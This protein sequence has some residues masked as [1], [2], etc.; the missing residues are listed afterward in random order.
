MD[1]SETLPRRRREKHIAVGTMPLSPDRE[2][3][4]IMRPSYPLL[5]ATL[6][7]AALGGS[8]A[9]AQAPGAAAGVA[10]DLA[11]LRA[12]TAGFRDIAAAQAAGYPT[13]TPPCLANPPAGGMGHHYVNR[14]QVDGRLELEHP[15]ILLYAPDGTGKL[16]LV[17]VEYIIPY[18][19]LPP[20]SEA[21][22]IFGQALRQ[23]ESLKL[24][25]LHVWAWED[26]PAGLFADWNPAVTC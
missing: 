4:T 15:E 26:N 14:A 25:Y 2:S 18:R 6:G 20:D 16:K 7:A 1:L 23:S 3:E 22:R 10:D 21:P 24:W 5:L 17:A 9:H 11:R 8:H 12:A 19:I 13:S